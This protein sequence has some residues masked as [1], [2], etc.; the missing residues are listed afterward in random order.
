MLS[1]FGGGSGLQSGLQGKVPDAPAT[2]P[3]DFE[4][5]THLADEFDWEEPSLRAIERQKSRPELG[6][7]QWKH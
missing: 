3:W 2:D 7:D 4:R 5:E 6:F 1:K